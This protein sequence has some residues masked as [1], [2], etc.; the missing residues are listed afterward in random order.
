MFSVSDILSLARAAPPAPTPI[1][2]FRRD[3]LN[4]IHATVPEFIGPMQAR[5][6]RSTEVYS[7]YGAGMVH[8]DTYHE[9]GTYNLAVVLLLDVSGDDPEYIA[10]YDA[11]FSMVLSENNSYNLRVIGT[12]E[13]APPIE[14]E[15]YIDRIVYRFAQSKGIPIY[16]SVAPGP[17][18]KAANQRMREI[19]DDI[20]STA[21]SSA[22]LR[23][24]YEDMC[25]LVQFDQPPVQ[26]EPEAL[27][28]LEKRQW[29]VFPQDNTWSSVAA[30]KI[31]A[32]MTL[33]ISEF[34]SFEPDPEFDL[35]DFYFA[36]DIWTFGKGLTG[37]PAQTIHV[38]K[39]YCYDHVLAHYM[40]SDADGP[41][42]FLLEYLKTARNTVVVAK[43]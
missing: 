20:R 39:P 22:E 41:Y 23:Q 19:L 28:Q 36:R 25:R 11:Y 2:A 10:K 3:F 38:D 27:C 31:C 9:E 30:G 29:V 15:E 8:L 26:G 16:T 1:A 18:A 21:R 40:N 34:L 24:Q 33:P 32:V 43:E 12:A 6:A 37:L 7:S 13:Q 17:E 35:Y 5:L 42:S 14:F 4:L